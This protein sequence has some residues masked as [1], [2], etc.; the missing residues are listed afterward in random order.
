MNLSKRVLFSL[1]VILFLLLFV[2]G[3]VWGVGWGVYF[4]GT[5]FISHGA[6]TLRQ[7]CDLNKTRMR[8]CMHACVSVSVSVCVCVCACVQLLF[9]HP[10]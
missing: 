4:K 6:M 1:E 7:A 2:G 9:V 3:G 5:L 8:L 10:T